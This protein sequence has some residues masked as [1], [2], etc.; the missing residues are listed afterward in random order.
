MPAEALFREE[1]AQ[2]RVEKVGLSHLSLELGHL[3]MEDYAAGYEHLR[4]TFERV[5]PWSDAARAACG[6]AL[7]GGTAR[8]STC[9]LVDDYFTP[10]SSPLELVP[11][12]RAAARESG[13]EIDYLVRESGCAQANGVSLAGL[14]ESRLVSDPVPGT[15]GTRP[16]TAQSGWATNGQRSPHGAAG[17]AMEG[18]GPWR[19][20]VENAANRHSIFMDV[21]LWDDDD[22]G[23]R[24]WSCPFLAA[25]WQLLRLGLLRHEG[26]AVAVPTLIEAEYPEGW[27]ELPAVVQLRRGAA[28]F[29][30]YRTFSVLGARFLPVEHAVLTILSQVGVEAGVAGEVLARAANEH[31]DLPPDIVQRIDYAF[32]RD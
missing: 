13:L 5:K 17:Q 7:A 30:A 20:P 3:Y 18:P 4:R 6:Q 24:T 10:F 28:P 9:Y 22:G 8:V 15:N 23:R 31:L 14:V 12:L 1:A 32:V 29:C 16:P 2:P 27:T 19:P 25:V 21:Q 11:Q 26:R